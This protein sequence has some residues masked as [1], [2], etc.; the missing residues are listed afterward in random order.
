M[1]IGLVIQGPLTS[2]GLTGGSVGYGKTRVKKN[3]FVE[4]DCTKNIINNVESAKV[5]FDKIVISTWRNPDS[6]LT[7]RAKINQLSV[8]L[9]ESDDPLE[10]RNAPRKGDISFL[11]NQTRQFQ[12][13]LVG[14]KVLK[15]HGIEYAVKIRSD[16]TLDLEKLKTCFEGFI[17]S[18]SKFFVPYLRSDIPTIIPDF[19]LGGSL[20][21]LQSLSY[22]LSSPHYRFHRNVHRD[23]FWKAMLFA[24]RSSAELNPFQVIFEGNDYDMDTSKFVQRH[25][26]SIFYPASKGLYESLIWRGEAVTYRHENLC[27][28]G[29]VLTTSLN[30]NTQHSTQDFGLITRNVAGTK[31]VLLFSYILFFWRVKDYVRKC[32][33]FLSYL[34]N[35]K[36]FKV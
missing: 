29:E 30:D 10:N 15:R 12:S 27:F 1:S 33:I 21:D 26:A 2:V 24:E 11:D 16:Q 8:D 14:L 35:R 34:I 32:R 6:D 9:I 13:T 4:F 18:K 22:M 17:K 23:I 25:L 36:D 3:R 5:I 31:S 28:E 7:S 19:Y 20:V